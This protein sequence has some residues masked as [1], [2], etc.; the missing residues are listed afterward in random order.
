M[1]QNPHNQQG[2]QFDNIDQDQDLD[3][4]AEQMASMNTGGKRVSAGKT[5]TWNTFLQ[6]DLRKK[7]KTMGDWKKSAAL[8]DQVS[9]DWMAHKRKH[10]IKTA[11][12]KRKAKR[13]GRGY[14]EDDDD[15][16]EEFD[17]EEY[18]G[19][20]VIGGKKKRKAAKKVERSTSGIPGVQMCVKNK[21]RLG[22]DGNLISTDCQKVQNV[23]PAKPFAYKIKN[24]F[25]YM[26]E[27]GNVKLTP[28]SP[29]QFAAVREIKDQV[30]KSEIVG[31]FPPTL[32]IKKFQRY[33]A[34]KLLTEEYNTTTNKLLKKMIEKAVIS[35]DTAKL[36]KIKQQL[37]A[38]KAIEEG[39]SAVRRSAVYPTPQLHTN[40][41]LLLTSK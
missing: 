15:T 28:Q 34:D 29:K 18:Q 7:N 3:D 36:D 13:R 37:V 30:K 9:A 25:E 40:T 10:G 41:Q 17:I 11:P 31:K 19:M 22:L 6:K 1:Q 24:I 12:K 27:D 33:D 38:K 16:D 14:D 21:Y 2:L 39:T 26:D 5:T 32:P 35:G 20:G 23:D 8:R 4:L